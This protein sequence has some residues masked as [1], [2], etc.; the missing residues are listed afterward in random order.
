[1]L[2]LPHRGDHHLTRSPLT[3]VKTW[4]MLAACEIF[5]KRKDIL[6]MCSVSREDDVRISKSRETKPWE[7]LKPPPPTTRNR[8]LTFIV[9]LSSLLNSLHLQQYTKRIRVRYMRHPFKE[10]STKILNVLK[11]SYMT[12]ILLKLLVGWLMSLPPL[13]IVT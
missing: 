1:M 3:N 4:D 6:K 2:L 13:L 7:P 9:S 12:L 11:G 8:S 5:Q 10:S